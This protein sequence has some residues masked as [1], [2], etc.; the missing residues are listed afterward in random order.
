MEGICGTESWGSDS[1]LLLRLDA[2]DGRLVK[3]EL[4]ADQERADDGMVFDC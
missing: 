4:S 1:V 2:D 3:V